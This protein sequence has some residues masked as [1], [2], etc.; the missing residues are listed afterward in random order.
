MSMASGGETLSIM[1]V[2]KSRRNERGAAIEILRGV[3]LELPA[4]R[5]TALIGPS[6]GGK[7]TLLRLLN[8]LED[9]ASGQILLSGTD[10]TQIDPLL[11]RRRI[12]VVP[13]VPYM[14][15][16]TVLDNLQRPFQ[17]R[18]LP[19][20][21]AEDDELAT[22]MELCR[23]SPDWLGR[24]ARSLS[25][26]Q[27]QRVALARTLLTGPGLLALDEPTSA[28]DQPTADRLGQTLRDICRQRRI[29]ILMLTHD[30]RLVRR[31][32][33]RVAFLA[34]GVVAEQGDAEQI[35]S[36]PRNDALKCFLTSFYEGGDCP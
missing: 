27:Q 5:L 36:A 25:I 9:P 16:G 8:R 4:E 1:A 26:G 29:T 31:I 3:D 34:D 30:L 20:P 18:G 12:G 7:S 23:L 14:Y 15:D 10:I 19:L 13:Q 6:G 2:R 17:F 32:A 28:L 35:F 24:Q 33:D 21:A 22:M 11:L